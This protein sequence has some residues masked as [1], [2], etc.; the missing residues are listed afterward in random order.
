MLKSA[1][2]N[3]HGGLSRLRLG[4]Y[5]WVGVIN[6]PELKGFDMNFLAYNSML[7]VVDEYWF[8]HNSGVPTEHLWCRFF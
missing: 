4:L 3:S 8:Y 5:G 6:L 7:Q 2:I 1:Q